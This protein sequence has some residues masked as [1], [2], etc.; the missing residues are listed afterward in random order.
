MCCQFS[1]FWTRTKRRIHIEQYIFRNTINNANR[2]V[3]NLILFISF[4]FPFYLPFCVKFSLKCWFLI[5]FNRFYVGI[6]NKIERR[7]N[8]MLLFIFYYCFTLR[9][10]IYWAICW[11]IDFVGKPHVQF[12]ATEIGSCSNK[13]ITM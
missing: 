8:K 4:N 12:E 11:S 6:K 7:K 5:I 1:V 3:M 9:F 13:W 2:T 10:N